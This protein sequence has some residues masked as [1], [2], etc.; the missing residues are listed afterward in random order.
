MNSSSKLEEPQ[1]SANMEDYL[2]A[3][4]TLSD[5]GRPVRVTRIS[6]VLHVSK[7]SVTAAVAKLAA[8]GLVS[9]ERYGGIYL[10]ERGR[11]LAEDVCRRHDALRMFL[12]R[13]L[14]VPEETAQVDACRLE[15]H[16][17]PE[18]SQRLAMF[19]S[20][21]VDNADG[22]R[23][24]LE[25]FS[26]YTKNRGRDAAANVASHHPRPQRNDSCLDG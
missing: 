17:S 13:I 15:H 18:S 7:P 9:H 20:F 1:Q 3:I 26:K 2:E 8:D 6:E 4:G 21:V 5:R 25:E 24:W 14:G 11:L 23:S 10:T 22:G 16:L 19:I 12:S